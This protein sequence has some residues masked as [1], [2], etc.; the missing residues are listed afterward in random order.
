[1]NVWDPAHFDRATIRKALGIPLDLPLILFVGRLAPEKRLRLA[2]R[3]LRDIAQHGVPFSALLIGE[4]PERPVLERM[5]RDPV[6]RNVRLIG[7]LPS[8]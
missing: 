6:L 3:I 4:G 7:A 8:E 5:L 1:M 2:M